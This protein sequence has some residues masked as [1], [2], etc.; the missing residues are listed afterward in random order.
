MLTGGEKLVLAAA[1]C[2][3]SESGSLRPADGANVL[4][5]AGPL[6]ADA[7]AVERWVYSVVEG[8]SREARSVL[9]R[10]AAEPVLSPIRQRL[11]ALGLLPDPRQVRSV[12][13]RLL[14]FLPAAVLGVARLVAGI[15]NHR[16]VGFLVVLLGVGLFAAV[17]LTKRP[18]ATLAGRRLLKRL[19]GDH[20]AFGGYGSAGAVARSPTASDSAERSPANRRSAKQPRSSSWSSTPP[21]DSGAASSDHAAPLTSHSHS[22]SD[23][24]P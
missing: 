3:L 5:I 16:P 22:S 9:D 18:L 11:W 13:L 24:P 23:P 19:E 7:A 6:P 15:H 21:S 20:G 12:R 2:R 10:D 4:T 17:T 14:W 1:A 8:G